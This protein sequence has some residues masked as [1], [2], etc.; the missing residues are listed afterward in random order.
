MP[1]PPSIESGTI[2]DFAKID[3]EMRGE[4][5]Y[6]R[7]GHT[8]R[9]LVREADLRVML[10]AMKA[11]SRIAKHVANE[12]ISIQ[13]LAGCLRLQLPRLARQHE[14]RFV[15]VPVGQLLVLER[16]TEHDVEAIGDSGFLLTL[17]W[18]DKVAPT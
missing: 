9:A 1:K 12:T 16:G 11:G 10:I 6:L 13:T 17:A 5:A 2:F 3:A 15:E 18:K 4:P 14:D 7:D 8:A